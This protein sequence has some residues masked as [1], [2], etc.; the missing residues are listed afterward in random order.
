[1]TDKQ[2]GKAPGSGPIHDPVEEVRRTIE[3]AS[4]SAR[5]DDLHLGA[6]VPGGPVSEADRA[7]DAATSWNGRDPAEEAAFGKSGDQKS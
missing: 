1:M 3:R 6:A 4:E 5:P 2:T 7:V